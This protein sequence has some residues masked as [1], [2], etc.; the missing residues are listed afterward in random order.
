MLYRYDYRPIEQFLD[1]D[2]PVH[3][4]MPCYI[5][6]NYD[7]RPIELFLDIDRPVHKDMQLY[8]YDYRPIELFWG[9]DMPVH[10]DMLCYTARYLMIRYPLNCF[11]TQA[12]LSIKVYCSVCQAIHLPVHGFPFTEDLF[13]CCFV[14]LFCF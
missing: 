10:K 3:E 2:M 4:D 12:C 9:I 11:Q 6:T 7:Y 1:I 13:C 14:W 8:R 5:D